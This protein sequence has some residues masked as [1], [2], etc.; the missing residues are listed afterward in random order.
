MS[1]NEALEHHGPVEHGTTR[2]GHWLPPAPDPDHAI[3]SRSLKGVVVAFRA[4]HLA[5]DHETLAIP[6]LTSLVFSGRSQ[7]GAAPAVLWI[8]ALHA[9]ARR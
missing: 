8:A 2:F 1:A 7:S 3:G 9:G 6:V 4:G 5:P